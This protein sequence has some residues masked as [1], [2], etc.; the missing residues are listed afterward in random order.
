MARLIADTLT[1]QFG[2][3]A[4]LILEDDEHGDALWL[5]SILDAGGRTL[6]S[7]ND[8]DMLPTLT[9]DSPL[10]AAWGQLDPADPASLEQ[11]VHG[12]RQANAIFDGVPDDLPCDTITDDHSCLLLSS[13]A[14][15][16]CWNFGWDFDGEDARRLARPYSAPRPP[17]RRRPSAPFP[18]PG[19]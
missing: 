19:R 5:H 8:A 14:R 1:T 6:F 9:G 16:G 13:D 15:P 18:A 11:A 7:F 10:R 3:A 12:L 2:D 4:Y 17:V